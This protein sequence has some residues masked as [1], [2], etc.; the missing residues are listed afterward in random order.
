LY[1]NQLHFSEAE[2]L[3]PVPPPSPEPD[4]IT[5]DVS[6]G[7]DIKSQ[8]QVDRSG[9][10]TNRSP[11]RPSKKAYDSEACSLER[12]C[13]GQIS[14]SNMASSGRKVYTKEITCAVHSAEVSSI[15]NM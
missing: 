3:S 10:V 5:N 4:A 15:P 13:S 1:A 2:T 14:K 8:K 9:T 11:P 12:N 7:S 6:G